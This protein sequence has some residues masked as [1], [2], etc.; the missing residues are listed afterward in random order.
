MYLIK[1]QKKFLSKDIKELYVYILIKSTSEG[2]QTNIPIFFV[3][4]MMITFK[5]GKGKGKGK[6]LNFE[7]K[8]PQNLISSNLTNCRLL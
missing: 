4:L 6:G 2:K 7:V 8:F 1:K 5:N 3:L